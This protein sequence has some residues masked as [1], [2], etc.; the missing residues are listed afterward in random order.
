MDLSRQEY[1]ASGMGV[2]LAMED[3]MSLV[4]IRIGDY[5]IKTEH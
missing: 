2:Q 5:L 3:S 4:Y 1:L